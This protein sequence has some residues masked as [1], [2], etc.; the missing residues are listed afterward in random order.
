MS[1]I[2]FGNVSIVNIQE[3]WFKMISR[4]FGWLVGRFDRNSD[5][6]RRGLELFLAF[7]S[8]VSGIG[9]MIVL[10]YGT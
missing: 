2:G 4:E 9:I 5:D 7:W 8:G 1:G 3:Y 6:I 10:R